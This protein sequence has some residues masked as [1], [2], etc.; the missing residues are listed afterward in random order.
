[1]KKLLLTI[2]L[3]LAFFGCA[4]E[5]GKTEPKIITVNYFQEL[6]T[7]TLVINNTRAIV[8]SENDNGYICTGGNWIEFNL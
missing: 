1:M 3:C 5:S 6:P 2:I 8:S 4:P 7:C